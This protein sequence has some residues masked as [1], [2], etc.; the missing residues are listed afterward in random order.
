MT[1]D[2]QITISVGNNRHSVSWSKTSML[3]SE[4]YNRLSLPVRGAETIEQYFALPKKEK[5]NLKDVGGFVGGE[6]KGSR[7]KATDVIGRDVVTLDFDNVPGWYTEKL[8]ESVTEPLHERA[9][10]PQ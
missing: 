1:H 6:L 5:D 7:R 8:I 10:P 2:R 4:L 3:V 9:L